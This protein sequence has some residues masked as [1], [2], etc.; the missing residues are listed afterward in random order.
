MIKK[1]LILITVV[2]SSLSYAQQGSSSPYS[3]Y[4]IGSLKFKGTVENQSMG[5]LSVYSDSIHI[6]LRNPASYAGKNL[7]SFNNEA[8]PVKYTIGGSHSDIKLSSISLTAESSTTSVDYLA[9]AFP[10]GKFGA[11][12]GLLP[13][14]SV[15]Y[16]LQSTDSDGAIQY[17]YRGEGGLN[18]VFLGV[19]YQ[20]TN[21]FRLGVDASYNFGNIKNTNIAFGYNSE[22]GL[23][24]YQ[25]RESNRSDLGGFTYNF[26]LIFS[27]LIKSNFEVTASA[28]YSPSSEITS[29]NSRIYST[30]VIDPI[31]Q[32]E[33]TINTSEIDLSDLNLETTTLTLPSKTSFGF[34]VGTP[35]KWFA[36]VEYTFLKASQF[37]N[38]LL[39]IDNATYED[40][41]TL[42]LGGFY[43][44][45]YDS[46]NRYWKRIVYRAGIRFE[47]T[48]L[49]INNE[50]IKEFGISFGVGLPVGRIFSNANVGFEIGTRG[51]DT[52]NLVKENFIKFQVSLSLNDR[53]FEKRKFN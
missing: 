20:L 17:K 44:P 49:R 22:G 7:K 1:F 39:T 51:V 31:S 4:G 13:Y 37:S 15:G 38:R 33:F 30:I 43:I 52:A 50:D 46:F 29:A 28:T 34:G 41:S 53:W 35:R 9:L 21:D 32:Q 24:Q 42:S 48:G 25:S 18:K 12:F 14:S 3:F 19:G 16:K 6:N 5:G 40:G 45:K 26:G 36:G 10:L 23:L 27:K 47:D 11:G 2:F 8:K